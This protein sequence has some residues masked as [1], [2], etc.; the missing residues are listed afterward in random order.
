MSA[1]LA[2]LCGTDRREPVPG[3]SEGDVGG[4]RLQLYQK[5]S[6]HI[7]KKQAYSNYN[8]DIYGDIP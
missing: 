6:M 5:Q 1:T 4:E 2:Q 3:C 7:D 8:G